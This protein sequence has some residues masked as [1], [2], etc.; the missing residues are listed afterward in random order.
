MYGIIEIIKNNILKGYKIDSH[1]HINK[2]I[3]K[4]LKQI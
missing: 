3:I 4:N 1:Y 2:N